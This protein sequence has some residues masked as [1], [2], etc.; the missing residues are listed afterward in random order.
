MQAAKWLLFLFSKRMKELKYGYPRKTTSRF[1][2][3]QYH[4][5]AE[6]PT[7]RAR[8]SPLKCGPFRAGKNWQVIHL[9]CGI[10]RPP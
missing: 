8:A 9:W 10:A 1:A 6:Q 3:N 2:Q 7:W 5:G 4:A